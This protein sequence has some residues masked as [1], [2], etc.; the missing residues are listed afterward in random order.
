M[1]R[2]Y[3]EFRDEN[4][5]TDAEAMR[6][7]LREGLDDDPVRAST[8]DDL[9]RIAEQLAIFGFVLGVSAFIGLAPGAAYATGVVL[10][11]AAVPFLIEVKF[12]PVRRLAAG[13]RQARADETPTAPEVGE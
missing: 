9:L 8:D 4:D 13:V 2:R 7:L 6:Y 3:E 11:S 10:V 12:R 1:D 5:M